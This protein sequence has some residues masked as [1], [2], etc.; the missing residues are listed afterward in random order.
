MPDWTTPGT[1]TWRLLAGRWS[2]TCS[3]RHPAKAVKYNITGIEDLVLWIRRLR[4]AHCPQ[5]IS[6][7]LHQNTNTAPELVGQYLGTCE[8]MRG[9][10]R[11]GSNKISL[12][13]VPL[14]AIHNRQCTVP[15][16]Y[17]QS[18]AASRSKPKSSCTSHM[19]SI[20]NAPVMQQKKD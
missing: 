18:Q 5:Y 11:R 1:D 9:N 20:R 3:R 14:Y 12:M 2:F 6:I 4:T 13:F 15:A 19:V 8:H 16:L 10:G 17:P 7:Y